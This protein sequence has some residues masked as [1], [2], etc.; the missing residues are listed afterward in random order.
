MVCET[1]AAASALDVVADS[2]DDCP[3]DGEV[4]FASVA[5]LTNGCVGKRYG[6]PL[7]ASGFGAFCA[8]LKHTTTNNVSP[9]ATRNARNAAFEMYCMKFPGY[10]TAP[11]E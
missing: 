4:V 1:G 5:M 10:A 2:D 7:M 8:D 6:R 9:I 11:L 3:A